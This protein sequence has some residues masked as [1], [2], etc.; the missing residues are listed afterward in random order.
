M[1]LMPNNISNF[2]MHSEWLSEGVDDSELNKSA[3]QQSYMVATYRVYYTHIVQTCSR[4]QTYGKIQIQ[5]ISMSIPKPYIQYAFDVHYGRSVCVCACAC[6][7]TQF[8]PMHI[9]HV[10]FS[11]RFYLILW[12]PYLKYTRLLLSKTWMKLFNCMLVWALRTS[13]ETIPH[14][15]VCTPASQPAHWVYIVCCTISAHKIMQIPT[16]PNNPKK[17]KNFPKKCIPFDRNRSFSRLFTKRV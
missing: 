10:Q 4:L 17:K 14:L 13:I 2:N 7:D 11:M 5:Q 12:E 8:C 3:I 15:F 1:C 6:A 9:N 16:I